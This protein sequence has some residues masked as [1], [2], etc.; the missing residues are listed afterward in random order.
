MRWKSDWKFV[1][2]KC[3]SACLSSIEFVS[4]GVHTQRECVFLF[5]PK[6]SWP[7]NPHLKQSI[8]SLFKSNPLLCLFV[9]PLLCRYDRFSMCKSI[10]QS[11][12][13]LE[14]EPFK[15]L[16]E[17]GMCLFNKS[18]FVFFFLVLFALLFF[19]FHFWVTLHQSNMLYSAMN[20][21]PLS[22][23]HDDDLQ[24]FRKNRLYSIQ[25]RQRKPR[26]SLT[27]TRKGTI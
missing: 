8:L 7:T 23:T 3:S 25:P 15:Q 11:Y 18:C 20:T 10:H 21:S 13:P 2:E 24:L 19:G 26:L 1:S 14:I 17:W 16:F 6:G 5:M 27:F 22:D 4:G 12:I 9:F